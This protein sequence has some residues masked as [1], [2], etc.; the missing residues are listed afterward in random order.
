L[1]GRTLGPVGTG[2]RSSGLR[3]WPERDCHIPPD[4]YRQETGE[5]RFA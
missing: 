1:P 2:D 3:G 5:A 4:Y